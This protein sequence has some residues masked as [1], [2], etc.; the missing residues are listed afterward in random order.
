MM[1]TLT[2]TLT[3]Q[4]HKGHVP[5][6]FDVP[7]GTTRIAGRF[8]ASPQRAT[9][10]LFDNLISLSIFGPDGCRGAR[11]NNRDMD[12]SID[13][14]AATPGYT[15]GA[16]E[17]GCWTV[18][19]DTFR[20][21]GPDPVQYELV[22]TFSAEPLVQP[23]MRAMPIL[24][25]HGEGW[26]R[27]DIHAHTLHSDG[28]WDIPDL[29]NWAKTHG[30]DFVTLT[31]HNTVSGHGEMLSLGDDTLLTMGGVELTTHYG[32]CLSL[33]DRQ[34]QDWR[35][36]SVNGRTMPDIARE[37]MERGSVFI[38]AH[39]R[40]PG[41]PSCTGCRWEYEDMMPGP[42]RIVE[43]WNGGAWSDY[44]EE[45]LSLFYEWLKSGLQ[46]RATSGSDIHRPDDDEPLMGFNHVFAAERSE[47]AIFAAIKAGRNYL[48]SGPKLIL[49]A[50][51]E[52]GNRVVMGGTV[53]HPKSMTVEWSTPS[54]GLTLKMMGPEGCFASFELDASSEGETVI[55]TLPGQFVMAELRDD[56]GVLRAVTNP[57]FISA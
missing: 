26:Y 1:V 41:D 22:I 20:I 30:L 38:I 37:V 17:P 15:A 13:A 25:N 5:L 54:Q 3:A 6:H 53:A 10:A 55:E 12:F 40:A 49:S 16:I 32:H 45:G 51:D 2:G 21:I 28:G 29:V 24:A 23:P 44:N 56:K 11:H 7:A 47:A 52:A 31:D 8:A 9:N 36:G 57:V 43:I 42:A 19:M 48:S 35:T 27:G 33:G 14:Y 4:D 18:F 39:P 34:W 50:V 46:M